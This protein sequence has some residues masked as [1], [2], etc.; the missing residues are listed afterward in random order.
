MSGLMIKNI[1]HSSKINTN[2]IF[3]ASRSGFYKAEEFCFLVGLVVPAFIHTFTFQCQLELSFSNVS[4]YLG[5]TGVTSKEQG[6][7]KITALGCCLSAVISV[8]PHSS[9]VTPNQMQS[10]T[11]SLKL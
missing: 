11:S 3:G 7:P 2:L 5:F 9:G 8:A 6:V 1:R 10:C 4:G